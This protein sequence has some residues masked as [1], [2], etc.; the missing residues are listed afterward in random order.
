LGVIKFRLSSFSSGI[1][2]L[3]SFLLFPNL[4]S[5]QCGFGGTNYGN[6]TPG[7]VGQTY[8]LP[9]YVWGGDQ[10]TLSAQAG[11]TYTISTC[12]GGW[13]SQITVF[14][15]NLTVAGYNDDACGLQ[16]QVTFTAAATG[17][18]TIQVNVFFCGSNTSAI[19]NF[20]VTWVSCA[21]GGGCTDNSITVNM[22]DSFGD[23]WN[24][25][26]YTILNSNGVA[27]ATGTLPGGSAATNNHCL[28]DGC[29]TMVVT[30]GSFPGE[31]SWSIGGTSQGTITGGAPA[32]VSFTLGNAVSVG[33]TD[34]NAA[35]YDPS[36]V[37]DDGSCIDCFDSN[38]TGCPEIDAGLDIT[39][40]ECFDPCTNITLE[41]EFFET[42]AT[43]SYTVCGIDYAPPYPFNTGTAIFINQDDVYGDVVNLPFNFCFYGNTYNQIVVGANGLVSFN[44]AYAN[45]YC[46]WAF[47]E[48]VPNAALPLNAIFGPYHDI[49]PSVC[50]NV[51]YAILG[52]APCRV[53][54][55]NFDEVCH[56]SCN[57][58]ISSSQIVLYETTNAIEVY[59]AN[60][61]TCGGWNGGRA[62]IGIQNAAGTVGLTPDS[63]QTGPWTANNE[64]WR[65]TPAGA[66]IV[67][68]NWYSQADGFIGSGA[69]IEVCPSEAAQSF[70]AEAV[71]ARCDGTQITVSDA[72]NVTCAMVLLP[73][74]WLDFQAM[75]V[76]DDQHTRCT[77]QTATELNNDYFTI[78]RSVDGQYWEAIGTVQGA[79]TTHDPQ[80]YEWLDRHPYNGLSYYRIKQTDYNGAVDY[81]DI[82]SIERKQKTPFA[83]YPNPGNQR[84][85]LMGYEAGDLF[86][87][88]ALGRRVPF[89]LTLSGE[90]TL[91][92]AASGTYILE[93]RNEQGVE[94]ERIRLVIQ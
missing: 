26:V 23:G 20:N 1:L 86:V 81:S 57:S 9:N 72:V 78:E 3:A 74:E 64:A 28:P 19:P 30:A 36:A 8:S 68:V 37:C 53:F 73:V 49:D 56:F 35:N 70:V 40:P 58:L 77:W 11:C 15:P 17:D 76:N 47:T 94:S 61:P 69:S 13:D 5:A 45:A 63:R 89:S 67:T 38:P 55:V 10:F 46:P 90:L 51:R 85:T 82:R 18:Y 75:L 27:V 2:F 80:A 41:A 34:P 92:G 25:S 87:F 6:V 33:C 32:N 29:Y 65:F 71:Y 12:G 42:G 14:A 4:G 84:F 7:G 50:G 79:G 60:K 88:D 24:G 91:H 43:T 31:V 39:L 62:V 44:T 83:V 54:V 48:T 59:V 16:S 66:S 52:T 93:L 21:G 22:A